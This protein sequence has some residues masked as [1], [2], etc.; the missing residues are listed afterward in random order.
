[1]AEPA[2]PGGGGNRI[3]VVV[4]GIIV[5]ISLIVFAWTFR[6]CIS[7]GSGDK[8]DGSIK[9]YTNLEL[10]DTSNV[11]ARLKDLKI[12][13]EVRDSGTS[14]AVPKEKADEARL[15]LAEKNLPMFLIL[16]QFILYR[17]G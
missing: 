12:P 9:I 1:M 3:L 13:Y 4:V 8:E 2:L 7:G 11:V 14:V 6:G 15:G 16:Q 5:L 10:K 17:D